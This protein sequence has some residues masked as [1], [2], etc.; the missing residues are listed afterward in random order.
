MRRR[1]AVHPRAVW[2]AAGNLLD[3]SRRRTGVFVRL[4]GPLMVSLALAVPTLAS[5]SGG[6]SLAAKTNES[7]V[8]ASD[9]QPASAA[10]T[11]VGPAL[12][13]ELPANEALRSLPVG[14]S[15]PWKFLSATTPGP[16]GSLTFRFN[17]SKVRVAD[18]SNFELVVPGHA[19]VWNHPLT[20]RDVR[21][22]YATTASATIVV[23]HTTATDRSAVRYHPRASTGRV[24]TPTPSFGSCSSSKT[25]VSH[26]VQTIVGSTFSQQAYVQGQ[27]TFQASATSSLG[28]AETSSAKDTTFSQTA[29]SL[30]S[31]NTEIPFATQSG[32]KGVAFQTGFE[33]D[34]FFVS[35]V[36]GGNP[37]PSTHYEVRSVGHDG[38]ARYLPVTNKGFANCTYYYNGT[39][40]RKSSTYARMWTGGV[41]SGGIVGFNLTSQTGFSSTAT[42]QYTK[43]GYTMAVC[44]ETNYPGR[45]NAGYISAK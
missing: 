19:G 27:V 36:Y 22:S 7:A 12:L 35:C 16:D 30:V 37:Y 34:K 18:D 24:A 33:F 28:V 23:P 1:R 40:F 11:A 31:S 43:H 25:S 29:T 8:A 20:A 10:D 41:S 44:G 9:G 42:L 6:P 3:D 38:G 5:A 26:N 21:S 32:V 13:F 14:R 2:H 45:A 15:L 4:I 39:P 17:G